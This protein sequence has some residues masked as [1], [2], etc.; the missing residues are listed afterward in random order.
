[1]AN[2]IRISA[3]VRVENGFFKDA[4]LPAPISATQHG[5]GRAGHLQGFTVTGEGNL[6]DIGDIA[7]MGWMV[8]RN[9]DTTNSVEWGPD[10]SGTLVVI[11]LLEPG[12]F[13]LLRLSPVVTLFRARSVGIASL[14]DVR[15]YED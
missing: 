10:D 3:S 7:A 5:V 9:V 4:F 14:L 6:I 12:E 15:I 2:E 11:G 1:M 8:L 13:A